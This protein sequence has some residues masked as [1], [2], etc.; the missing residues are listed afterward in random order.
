MVFFSKRMALNKLYKK[1]L[2]E[3]PEVADTSETVIAFLSDL[4]DE[5]MV[6]NYLWNHD[7]YPSK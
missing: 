2:A 6:D 1:W 3:N 7:A 5:D 4:L